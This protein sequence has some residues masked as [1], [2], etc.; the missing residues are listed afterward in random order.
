MP[1]RLCDLELKIVN[2]ASV[3]EVPMTVVAAL[4]WWLQQTEIS[5]GEGPAGEWYG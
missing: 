1:R 3:S 2:R 5:R 4:Y